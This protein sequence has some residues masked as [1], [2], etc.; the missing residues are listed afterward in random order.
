MSRIG[1]GKGDGVGDM[2]GDHEGGE[3]G[4]EMVHVDRRQMRLV[5]VVGIELVKVGIPNV[6]LSL[7]GK[8]LLERGDWIDGMEPEN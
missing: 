1:D 3:E 4:M 5:K 7:G 6:E 8:G 2:D